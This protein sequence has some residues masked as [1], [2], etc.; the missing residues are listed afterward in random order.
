MRTILE[1]VLGVLVVLVIII[2]KKPKKNKQLTCK[3]CG[4]EFNH[5]KTKEVKYKFSG[6]LERFQECPNCGTYNKIQ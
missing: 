6:K 4:C 5:D 3:Y 2:M 1:V